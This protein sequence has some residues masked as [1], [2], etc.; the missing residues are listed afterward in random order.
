MSTIDPNLSSATSAIGAY[1]KAQND[2]AQEW[3]EG[4]KVPGYKLPNTHEAMGMG[5]VYYSFIEGVSGSRGAMLTSQL[6][7]VI[8]V[9]GA[10]LPDIMTGYEAQQAEFCFGVKTPCNMRVHAI[11]H[12][13]HSSDGSIRQNPKTSVIYQDMDH[14]GSGDS[15]GIMQ[16]ESHVKTHNDF[17]WP[18]TYTDAAKHLAEGSFIPK[19]TV[20]T[21]S[22]NV[23]YN[24]GIPQYGAGINVNM[25]CISDHATIED[26][27]EV[28]DTLMA[29]MHATTIGESV[30]ESGSQRFHLKMNGDEEEY[31]ICPDIGKRVP[32]S[33]VLLATRPYDPYLACIDMSPKYIK[34]VDTVFDRP[35]YVKPGSK[36]IDIDIV[37]SANEGRVQTISDTMAEQY[38]FY[39]DHVSYYSDQLISLYNQ[40][41]Q[42]GGFAT[43]APTPELQNAVVAAYADKPNDP[44]ANYGQ[45][46]EGRIRRVYRAAG[47]DEFRV[48]VKFESEFV[49][50]LSAKMTGLAGD[51]GVV[52]AI[53]PEANMPID[54]WGN[55]VHL[56]VYGRTAIAR[57]NSG[58]LYEPQI[59]A[60]ARDVLSDI[61]KMLEEDSH[62]TT[63][64]Y[65]YLSEYYSI[66]NPPAHLAFEAMDNHGKDNHFSF[67]LQEERIRHNIPAAS[68]WVD[69]DLYKR[70][71]DF[72][73]VN[74]GPLTY[75]NTLG[76]TI[77]TKS[78]CLV[79]RK[80][81]YI[82][83]KSGTKAMATAGCR[84]QH[85]G[86][87][88]VTNKLLVA[89]TPSK[90]RAARAY[91]ES[92][93]RVISS[94]IGAWGAAH[95]HDLTT[96]PA[97]VSAIGRSIALAKDPAKMKR[98]VDRKAIP[99]GNS[100]PIALVNHLLE[101]YGV[102]ISPSSYKE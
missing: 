88:A 66:I 85:H 15:Y 25:A 42:A 81:F 57:L 75:V 49:P 53:T 98:V 73:P 23:H 92:E 80:Y 11:L 29:K 56:K 82:L 33:G 31:K 96:N 89:T 48:A 83:E 22:S 67:I 10:E 97:C 91:G 16:I 52:C 27:F 59:N 72:R 78:N 64:A 35:V 63:R 46:R 58:W 68:D 95:I 70:L 38:R 99:L 6:A 55:R 44:R 26:G 32:E 84:L 34:R 54:Q 74:M 24:Y 18:V 8:Q 76:E 1:Y 13:Y 100:R 36:V 62:D 2:R 21:H 9:K 37:S 5:A 40:I 102:K 71:Q 47:L 17:G 3:L 41:M 86:M 12:K 14:N 69:L 90:E 19:G 30:T 61:M 101:C 79:G 7:Q 94:T 39:A 93:F 4:P 20:M 28:S 51:K 50:E 43:S 77:V 60:H 87:P 65:E 45:M